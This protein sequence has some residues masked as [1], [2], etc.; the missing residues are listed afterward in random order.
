MSGH[1]IGVLADI[2]IGEGRAFVVDGRQIAVYRM[3]DNSLRAL[4]AACP[5]RGGPLADGLLDAGIVVCPLHG[6]GYDLG[7]GA[8]SDGGPPACPHTATADAD[9]TVRVVL[10]P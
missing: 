3:R 1:V 10:G 9:G 4:D 6:R 8:E 7:T 5:H 2:P